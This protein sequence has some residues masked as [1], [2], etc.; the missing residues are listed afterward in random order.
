MQHLHVM[1]DRLLGDERFRQFVR[2]GVVG[3]A[4]SAVHYA[5]Y[6]LMLLMMAATAA[7]A[8]G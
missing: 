3:V 6:Y 7:Y 4:S 2:F 1:I 8:V 5:I